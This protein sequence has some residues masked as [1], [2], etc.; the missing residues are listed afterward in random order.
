METQPVIAEVIAIGDELTTGQRLDT[1]SPWLSERLT[2]MGV[3]VLYHTTVADDLEANINVFRTAIERADVV[4]ATGGLGPTDDDLT[5]P[6]LAAAID[7]EL[8]LDP[9][10]EQHIR[11]LFASRGRQMPERNVVQAM[12]PEGSQ[13]IPNPNGTAPG[14]DLAVS[15]SGRGG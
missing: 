7:V 14:I 11:N 12:F 9:S 10:S 15:R 8:A 4:V 6:A 1:N 13:A 3:R 5:R 2:S